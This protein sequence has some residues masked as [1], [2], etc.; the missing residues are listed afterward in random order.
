MK[1]RIDANQVIV[2]RKKYQAIAPYLNERSRRIWAASEAQTLGR[3][4][5]KIVHEATGLAC[6]TI[7]KGQRELAAG[8]AVEVEIGRIRKPGGGRK[9]KVDVDPQLTQ[10]IADI[11]EGS[12]RGDP[13]TP[14]LWTIKSTRT[15]A[16][17]LNQD[18]PR[19]SHSGVATI[20]DDLGYSLQ[21]NRKVKEG[22]A[23]PDRNAQFQYIAD[24]TKAFQQRQQ[25]VISVD[26]KKKELIGEYKNGGQ[27]YRPKGA[28]TL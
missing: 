8:E 17:E 23:H 25:P 14:L 24:K 28:P 10:A 5:Q 11:L 26:T 21:A 2:T 9:R 13:E 3:G 27:V 20:L 12:T 1:P 16:A 6:A 4:G 15:I 18:G 22:A 19:V 7:I